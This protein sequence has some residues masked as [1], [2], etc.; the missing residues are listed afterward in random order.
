MNTEIITAFPPTI[1]ENPTTINVSIY[2]PTHVSAPDNK[3]DVIRFRNILKSLKKNKDIPSQIIATLE[4]LEQDQ[5]FW[6]YHLHGLCILINESQ[7]VIYR[8]S[9][10]VTESVSVGK[11]FHIIPLIRNFQS[12]DHYFILGLNKKN[13]VLKLANRYEIQDF[14]LPD[15]IKTELTDVLGD[16]Y[17]EK[18]LNSI[19]V[20]SNTATFHG[21]GGRKEEEDVDT[22][23]FFN[24][25]DKEVTQLCQQYKMHVLLV[26]LPE[27]QGLFRNLSKNT[28]LLKQ[29]VDRNFD[30]LDPTSRVDIL[31]QHIEPVYE[32]KT[33]T[34]LHRYNHLESTESYQSIYEALEQGRVNQLI[35]EDGRYI[36]ATP[37]EGILH[38]SEHGPNI[39]N[40]FANLALKQHVEVVALPPEKMP[41]ERGC[42]AVLL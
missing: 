1:L 41:T 30:S 2:M 11:S 3:Q 22:Q 36:G 6:M 34:L 18:R 7:C 32:Q 9:R 4:T 8:L 13:F 37:I 5:S 39:L 17:T 42:F 31:W 29:G 14:T 33:E 12:D 27:H 21:V 28:W 23:R 25:V 35:V 24:Y 40:T 20:S 16:Q 15:T 19:S 10:H 26:A 38:F